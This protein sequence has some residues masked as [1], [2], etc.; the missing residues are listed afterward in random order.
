MLVIYVFIVPVKQVLILQ[1][2]MQ[3]KLL[4][5]DNEQSSIDIIYVGKYNNHSIEIIT[6]EQ[7]DVIKKRLLYANA[8]KGLANLFSAG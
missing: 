5:K 1:L 7:F 8:R 6:I 4:R 2:K 3:K